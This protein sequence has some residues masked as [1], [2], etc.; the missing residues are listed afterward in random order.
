LRIGLTDPT[1]FSIP[2]DNPF[3]KGDSGAGEVWAFGVQNPLS[4]SFDPTTK[5]VMLLD[6]G[7]EVQELDLIERGNNYGW[8]LVEG[9]KC[10]NAP[11]D[12][13]HI[14]PPVHSYPA[15]AGGS[16]VGGFFSS[17]T[18][19]PELK[20]AYIFADS[21]TKTLFKLVH[22]GNSWTT[23]PIAR[24]SFP[25]MAV[26]QGAQGEIYVATSDGSVSVVTP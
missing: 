14:T 6:S 4:L 8:N 16:A 12:L 21:H 19:I 3:A 7:R 18:S 9:G 11:C 10:V 5:R 13:S 26:G 1:R 15:S 24:A 2:S 20:G 17:G 23:H 25:I 22:S